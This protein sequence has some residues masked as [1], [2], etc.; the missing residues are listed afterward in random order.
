[1]WYSHPNRPLVAHTRWITLITLTFPCA[2]LKTTV[3]TITC[4]MSGAFPS[5]P[6]PARCRGAHTGNLAARR[7]TSVGTSILIPRGFAGRSASCVVLGSLGCARDERLQSPQSCLQC[8]ILLLQVVLLRLQFRCLLGQLL[9]Q[10]S[11]RGSSLG[12]AP[13]LV[14]TPP[15]R[16]STCRKRHLVRRVQIHVLQVFIVLQRSEEILPGL[17]QKACK[18]LQWAALLPYCPLLHSSHSMPPQHPRQSPISP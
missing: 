8:I 10:F 15:R 3:H 12:A 16:A 7:G 9:V 4:G 14:C 6:A 17:F 18:A 13:T 2:S 5:P 11:C 1:M